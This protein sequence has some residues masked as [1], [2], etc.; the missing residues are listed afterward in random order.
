[1]KNDISS[2][3]MD[4][5]CMSWK[6]ENAE[7]ILMQAM[8]DE[9]IRLRKTRTA[10]ERNEIRVFLTAAYESIQSNSFCTSHLVIH[11]DDMPQ[12]DQ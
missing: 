9:T 8:M 2:I 5:I 12:K 6:R 7:A 10:K 1:M 3:G 4:S 11:S